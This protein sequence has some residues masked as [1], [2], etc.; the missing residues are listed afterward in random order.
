M[1]TTEALKL[2]Y[3]K[4]GGSADVESI[5]SISDM[6][7]LIE[8]VA[9]GG[10]G[11]SGLVVNV[12]FESDFATLDKNYSEISTALDNGAILTFASHFS[13]GGGEMGSTTGTS[14]F[15]LSAIFENTTQNSTMY[16]VS[17]YELSGGAKIDFTSD[18]E[19]GELT[20]TM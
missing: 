2:L 8:D 20:Y 13:Q 5:T 11:A 12:T 7:D 3:K 14:Y 18:S 16:I 15:A 10:G 4:L 19:T 9:G 6:V 1:V 17:L